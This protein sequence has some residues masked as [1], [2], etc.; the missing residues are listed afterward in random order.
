MTDTA[1]ATTAERVA[2]W[3]HP[4][5]IEPIAD[6]HPSFGRITRCAVDGVRVHWIVKAWRHD[7]DEIVALLD[8]EYGGAWG[9]PKVV[10]S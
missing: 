2:A 4:H 8:A 3:R 7:H 6:E 5:K 1:T 10:A 9:Q